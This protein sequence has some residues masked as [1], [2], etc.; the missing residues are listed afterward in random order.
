MIRVWSGSKRKSLRFL[1][2]DRLESVRADD[3]KLKRQIRRLTDLMRKHEK[4]KSITF[5]TTCLTDG[6]SCYHYAVREAKGTFRPMHYRPTQLFRV[7]YKPGQNQSL[8]LKQAKGMD[9]GSRLIVFGWKIVDT[10]NEESAGLL[11]W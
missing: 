9:S 11:P 10:R 2:S 7:D 4:T 5:S 3:K 6:N 8:F 1:Q